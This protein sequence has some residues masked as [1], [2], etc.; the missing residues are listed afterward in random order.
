MSDLA[1]F[2]P[3]GTGPV[4]RPVMDVAGPKIAP[5][6]KSDTDQNLAG[7]NGSQNPDSFVAQKDTA[8]SPYTAVSENSMN[9]DT[10][11][12]PPPTFQISILELDAKLA[13]DLA[14]IN[15]SHTFG[16]EEIAAD[17]KKADT[18]DQAT[19]DSPE[20]SSKE[21]PESREPEVRDAANDK[22]QPAEEHADIKPVMNDHGA[23][24]TTAEVKV[25]GEE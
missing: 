17:V 9:K 1:T 4:A 13:M 14:R 5:V 18:A 8:R 12:G 15:A 2:T 24:G 22:P 20:V 6:Q 16:R 11:A 19:Q 23:V 21:Q 10:P 25:V 7:R 3:V